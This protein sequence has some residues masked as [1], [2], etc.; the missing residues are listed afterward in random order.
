MLQNNSVLRD[1]S[2]GTAIRL[3]TG[4]PTNRGRIPLRRKRFVSSSKSPDRLSNLTNLLFNR[5]GDSLWGYRC[6]D[7]KLTD[8]HMVPQLR[9]GGATSTSPYPPTFLNSMQR[10]NFAF[11]EHFY[12]SAGRQ[13]SKSMSLF[14]TPLR[15]MIWCL[16]RVTTTCAICGVLL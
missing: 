2:F 1:S 9:M 15:E 8:L 12:V 14:I 6:R 7:L 13:E 10:V 3:R 4:R 5:T 11:T 16:F